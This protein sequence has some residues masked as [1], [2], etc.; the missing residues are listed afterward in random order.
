MNA[1]DVELEE[2]FKKG[3][4]GQYAPIYKA[5]M[6]S[7]EKV[8]KIS[9]KNSKQRQAV[10]YSMSMFVKNHNYDWTIY[11]SKTGLDLYFVR[12]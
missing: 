11:K 3:D 12:A 1:L 5:W 6:D 4:L 9:C 10:Y 8:L 7:G 2:L